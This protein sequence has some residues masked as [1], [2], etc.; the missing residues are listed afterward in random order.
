MHSLAIRQSDLNSFMLQF[1]ISSQEYLGCLTK[2]RAIN[3]FH[4]Q[5]LKPHWKNRCSLF[6]I[7]PRQNEHK[8]SPIKPHTHIL[9]LVIKASLKT[10]HKRKECRGIATGFHTIFHQF[11]GGTFIRIASQVSE[12]TRAASVCGQKNQVTVKTNIKE[13]CWKAVMRSQAGET[14]SCRCIDLQ[15]MSEAIT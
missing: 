3:S 15:C 7:L 9:S 14:S 11:T 2:Q 1:S 5:L 6:S 4:M 12:H 13:A 10:S 8:Q